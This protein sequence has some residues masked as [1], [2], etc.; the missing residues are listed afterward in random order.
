LCTDPYDAVT[1]GNSC[2][3][4]VDKTYGD[5][6]GLDMWN[7]QSPMSEDCLNINVWVPRQSN[8]ATDAASDTAG[9]NPKKAVM[10]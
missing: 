1:L 5:F 3:Q 4:I 8:A 2:V 9:A 10:V 7:A 6:I